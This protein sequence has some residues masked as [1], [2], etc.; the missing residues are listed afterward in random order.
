[1]SAPTYDYDPADAQ[2]FVRIVTTREHA[3]WLLD[4]LPDFED[5]ETITRVALGGTD[6]Q[7]S[8]EYTAASALRSALNESP[9]GSDGVCIGMRY[10]SVALFTYDTRFDAVARFDDDDYEYPGRPSD[11]VSRENEMFRLRCEGVIAASRLDEPAR[12]ID[13]NNWIEGTMRGAV[14]TRRSVR[15]SII[16]VGD[17][18]GDAR[19]MLEAFDRFISAGNEYR[20]TIWQMVESVNPPAQNDDDLEDLPF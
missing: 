9:S 12:I 18:N 20:R 13:A 4:Q 19:E 17:P 3:R 11:R 16:M 8:E 14:E 7:L 1:M 6:P 2:R 15:R 5:T 10:R